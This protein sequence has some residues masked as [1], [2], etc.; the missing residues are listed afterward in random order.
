MNRGI[1]TTQ[2]FL[3]APATGVITNRCRPSG[4]ALFVGSRLFTVCRVWLLVTVLIVPRPSFHN[5]HRLSCPAVWP[6]VLTTP[7]IRAGVDSLSPA[8]PTVT[9]CI[10]NTM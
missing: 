1:R 4:A 10:H 2:H 3:P 7:V 8:K 6:T 5:A 9:L